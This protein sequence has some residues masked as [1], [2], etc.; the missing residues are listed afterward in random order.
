MSALNVEFWLAGRSPPKDAHNGHTRIC[1]EVFFSSLIRHN[2]YAVNLPPNPLMASVGRFFLENQLRE[3]TRPL[4]A[5]QCISVFII[6]AVNQGGE[7]E[8]AKRPRPQLPYVLFFGR[9]VPFFDVIPLS[10]A[11]LMRVSWLSLGHRLPPMREPLENGAGKFQFAYF[12]HL[13]IAVSKMGHIICD[14]L[15]HFFCSLFVAGGLRFRVSF[16]H[17]FR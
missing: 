6:S 4:L 12:R 13:C 15:P 17:T 11:L 2:S 8:G 14:A 1:V 16:P 5:Y 7:M 9:F 3:G 10:A